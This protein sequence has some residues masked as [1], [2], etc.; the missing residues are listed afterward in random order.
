MA[1]QKAPIFAVQVCNISPNAN[2][3]TVSDFFSFC[4][5]ITKLYLDKEFGKETSKAIVEF[6]TESASKTALLLTNALIV[7][8]PISVVP[9][10]PKDV[11]QIPSEPSPPGTPVPEEKITHRDFGGIKDEDRTKTSVLASM[12]ASGYVLA[13]DAVDKAKIYDEEHNISLQFKVGVE[14]LKVK[15]H[16]IDQQYKISEKVEHVKHQA[17]EKAKSLDEA[18]KISEKA[19]N[20]ASTVKSATLQA[21]AKAQENP[22]IK[23]GV[24]S[25]KFGWNS[26][27]SS[28]T[29]IYNDYKDQT[30]KAIEEKKKQQASTAPDAANNVAPN[31]EVVSEVVGNPE[32]SHVPDVVAVPQQPLTEEDKK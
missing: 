15:A 28:V 8:R 17:T 25:L 21:S 16:E 27:T 31:P 9:F 7:D 24:E 3:K 4:G 13:S 20:A 12:V 14:H 32:P 6:E 2:E 1:E 26:M 23:S 18:Y 29:G 5:K 22:T 19:S 10:P 11:Q 30:V